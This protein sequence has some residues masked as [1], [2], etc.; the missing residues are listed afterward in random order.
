MKRMINHR[1]RL[2]K[3]ARRKGVAVEHVE[4]WAALADRLALHH[5]IPSPKSAPK[6]F[7]YQVMECRGWIARRPEVSA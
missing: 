6:N 3:I 7:C 5:G 1:K 4:N 2:T